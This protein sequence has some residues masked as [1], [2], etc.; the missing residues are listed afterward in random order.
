M[1]RRKKSFLSITHTPK[2]IH[3]VSR[4][5]VRKKNVKSNRK[6]LTKLFFYYIIVVGGVRVQNTNICSHERTFAFGAAIHP[7]ALSGSWSWE[8]AP[9]KKKKKKDFF[10]P[11]YYTTERQGLSSE[12]TKIFL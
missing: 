1:R 2:A 12:L 6:E 3:K 9:A 11:F 5:R 8:L 10:S 4:A 7:G